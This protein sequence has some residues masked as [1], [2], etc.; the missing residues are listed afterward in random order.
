MLATVWSGFRRLA[1]L[2]WNGSINR[3]PSELTMAAILERDKQ[4]P[5]R[6]RGKPGTER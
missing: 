4:H 6:K 3:D 1:S 2:A 5:K